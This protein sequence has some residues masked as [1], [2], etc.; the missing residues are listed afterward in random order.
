[1]GV[2][3]DD[4][5]L[6]LESKQWKHPLMLSFEVLG[7]EKAADATQLIRQKYVSTGTITPKPLQPDH[8]NISHYGY[9][10]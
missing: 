6:R 2:M 7:D 10:E 3:N 9:I 8:S 4:A 5:L 1:M